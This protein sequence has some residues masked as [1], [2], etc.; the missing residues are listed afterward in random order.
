M[1]SQSGAAIVVVVKVGSQRGAVGGWVKASD[2]VGSLGGVA[3]GCGGDKMGSG[4][5]VTGDWGGD[6]GG[7]SEWGGGRLVW[8]VGSSG[9][10]EVGGRKS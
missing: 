7:K 2:M 6:K 1:G 9:Q 4:G 8:T 5:G 10:S 3:G